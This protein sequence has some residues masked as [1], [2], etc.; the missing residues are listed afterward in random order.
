[1][2]IGVK[3]HPD[4][5]DYVKQIRP[6]VDFFEVVAIEGKNYSFLKTEKTPLVVH[7]EDFKYQANLANPGNNSI[8]QRYLAFVFELLDELKA[9]HIVINPGVRFN[10]KCSTENHALLFKKFKSRKM[11]VENQPPLKNRTYPFYCRNYDEI[12]Q[13]NKLTKTGFCMDLA[14]AYASAFFFNREPVDFCDHMLDLDPKHV[15]I[16]NGRSQSYLDPHLHFDEGDFNM[17]QMKELIPR[18][19][20]VTLDTDNDLDAQIEEIKF[21][22]EPEY[23]N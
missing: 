9:K 10:N 18:D 1:M 23:S 13:F 2:K 14:H 3:I 16:S 19:A 15:H 8:N 17:V 22:K 7:A 6:Y 4:N 11:L 20:M 5:K 12:R 21:L